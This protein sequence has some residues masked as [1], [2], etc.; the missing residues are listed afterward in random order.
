MK[1]NLAGEIFAVIVLVLCSATGIA[2][3]SA[4]VSTEEEITTDVKSVVCKNTE[5]LNSVK[6]LFKKMGAA[7]EEM[8][9]EKIDD[10]ENLIVIKKG[11]TDEKVVIGAHYDK[12]SDGCGVIDNWTGIVVMA[13]IYRTLK[14]VDTQKTFVFVA[15]GKEEL[16]L[17]GSREMARAIPKEKRGEYCAMVNFD[18]F[19]HAYPQVMTNISDE[20]L[21]VLAKETAEEIK[22]PFSKAVIENASSDSESFRQQKIPGISIHGLNDKWQNFLHSSNDKIENV[23]MKAVYISYR[24]GLNYLAKID[25]KGCGDFRKE[26]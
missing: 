8:K 25:A 26:K 17:L 21:T 10:V 13:N 23:N 11:K 12:T 15:F 3:Q 9:V 22:L 24:Y 4:T 6:A 1:K 20:K 16:G 19:G 18:S 5:R 14:T 7:D 2:A